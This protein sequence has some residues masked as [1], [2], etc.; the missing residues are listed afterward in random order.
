MGHVFRARDTRLDRL[1]AIKTSREQ[2]DER[3]QREAR[4][5]AQLNHPHICTLHDVGSNYLV[6]ELIEGETLAKRLERG[7]LPT[8]TVLEYGRQIAGALAAAHSK[9]ITHRDLKPHNVMIAKSGVKVLDFGLAKT[10]GAAS[11]TETHA[12]LGTPA[13]MAPEQRLGGPADARSDIYAFGLVLRDMAEGLSSSPHRPRTPRSLSLRLASIIE[14]CLAQD[15]DDRWQSARDVGAAL[16]LVDVGDDAETSARSRDRTPWLASAG[17]F[18]ALAVAGIVAVSWPRPPATENALRYTLSAPAGTQLLRMG[19]AGAPALSPDGRL[20]AFVAQGDGDRSLWVRSLDAFEARPLPGTEGASYP[21]WS[22]DSRALG[23]AASGALKTIALTEGQPRVL[24]TGVYPATPGTWSPDGTI[25]FSP[26]NTTLHAVSTAGGE[27]ARATEMDVSRFEENHLSPVFLPDGRHYLL[28]VRGGTE[29]DYQLWVGELGSNARR[30]LLERSG[31]AKYAP[32]R[33]GAPGYLL[34]VRDG[35]L[36]AQE[37]DAARFELA[38]RP[39]TIADVGPSPTGAAGDFSVS[40]AGVLAYRIESPAAQELVWYDRSGNAVGSIGDT[41]GNPRSNVRLSPDG[42][43]VAF[44]RQGPTAQDVWIYDLERRA[45]SR[46]TFGGGR[47]PVW[48]PDGREIAFLRGETV[49]RKSADGA[50]PEVALWTGSGTLSVNDWSGDGA[51]LLLT[52]WTSDGRGLWLLPNPLDDTATHE[53]HLLESR[54]LHG[55]FAPANG[56]AR[57]VSYDDDELGTR[58]VF[59]RTMPGAP[60][61]KWQVSVGGG[62]AARWRDDG[63]EIYFVSGGSVSAVSFDGDASPITG[64][65]RRL[66]ATPLGITL[67]TL[68]YAP[69]YDVSADGER[70]ISTYTGGETVPATIHIVV[71]WQAALEDAR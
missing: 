26:T 69:G 14:R 18:V 64:P 12:V 51:Q 39:M 61:G 6:M 40:A 9:D 55:Q 38:G 66:F 41:S 5:V 15:P 29:L 36:F 20:I 1:V 7:P 8:A 31:N 67:A 62:N 56:T 11:L 28:Q 34:F 70:F 33:A 24:A 49:L 17:A 25:L 63:G 16:E 21:F 52:R 47:S 58:E 4:T 27:V 53:P 48:S 42:K 10:Q 68:W 45:T 30:L 3:F 19:Q 32:P 50:G 2:F 65:P 60:P 23:F 46:L 71:N 43:A 54:G 59:V 35:T 37:F 57:W 44:T 13:Y 22:P